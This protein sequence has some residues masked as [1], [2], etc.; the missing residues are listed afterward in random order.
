MEH[1]VLFST[2]AGVP[3]AYKHVFY[4]WMAIIILAI[5]GLLARRKMSL[6]PTGAQNVMEFI[7]GSLEDYT[8]ANMGEKG[9]KLAVPFLIGMFLFI[10]IQNWI[11]LL[12]GCDAPTANLNTTMALALC[13][14]F[15]YNLVGFMTWGIGYLK[16]FAGPMMGMAPLI[17][18]IEIISHCSRPI[19]LTLRL[20]G[21]I[22]G[23]EI[24]ILLFFVVAPIAGTLPVYALFTLAKFMQAF[25]FYMLTMLYLNGALDHAH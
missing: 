17:F 13:T 6:V 23:E 19:S 22:R 18:P 15:Y 11:G 14:F 20:F 24:V 16:H 3:D 5:I 12:P 1:P 2:L 10:L 4:T 7:V 25:I 8:I 21:N 9:R